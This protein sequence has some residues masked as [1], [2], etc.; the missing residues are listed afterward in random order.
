MLTFGKR[1]KLV[2]RFK[3]QYVDDTKTYWDIMQNLPTIHNFLVYL[4]DSRLI[5]EKEVEKFLNDRNA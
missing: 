5:N 3:N 2:T 1:D 4:I